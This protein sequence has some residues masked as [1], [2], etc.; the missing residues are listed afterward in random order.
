MGPFKKREEDRLQELSVSTPFGNLAAKGVRIS[1]ILT[2]LGVTI[3]VITLYFVLRSYDAAGEQRMI[4]AQRYS[5]LQQSMKKQ[6]EAQTLMTCIFSV[7]ESR[8]ENEFTTANSYCRK[9][10]SQ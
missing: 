4:T 5:E 9:I 8:R 2:I 6:V 1:D 7:P 10:S 3:G